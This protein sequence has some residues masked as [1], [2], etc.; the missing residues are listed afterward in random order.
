[1][2]NLYIAT[3]GVYYS[4][5]YRSFLLVPQ[6]VWGWQ[7]Y[8]PQYPDYVGQKLAMGIL[9]QIISTYQVD[10]TRLYVTGLSM[11]GGGTF[12]I[13]SHYPH[14]FAAAVPLSGWGTVSNAPIIKDIPIWAF[15]GA[16]DTVV[17]VSETDDMVNA[18]RAAGGTLVEYTRP[19]DVGHEGWEAFYGG[20]SY[21]NFE[22]PT[23]VSVDVRSISAR[24]RALV[25]DPGVGGRGICPVLLDPAA[26]VRLNCFH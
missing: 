17:P 3:H 7:D 2:D 11:G 8:G 1:M 16:A 19:P 26:I 13:I 20:I 4:P 10:T 22:R 5:Q 23:L 12:D 15:H 6:T 14:T 25:D 18:I 24:A 9:N 21:T